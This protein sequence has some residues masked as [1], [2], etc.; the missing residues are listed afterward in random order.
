MRRV[1][2]EELKELLRRREAGEKI[3]LEDCFLEGMDLSG[4][5]LHGIAFDRSDICNVNLEGAN[6]SACTARNACFKGSSLK[7][8]NLKNAILHS[9]D[10]RGCDLSGAD[11]CGADM[12]SSALHKA[13]LSGIVTDE[14]TKFFYM[15]C[16][17][18]G[19]FIGWKVCFGRKVVMLLVPAD[20]KRVQ[21]TTREIRCDKA[22]VLT[23]KSVDL[24]EQFEEA[25]SYVDE[26]FIYKRGEMVYAKNFE[27]NRFVESAGGI[28]I[29]MSREE[30][31][32]YM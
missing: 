1:A 19:A 9:A 12:F 8:A 29:W 31:V 14:H 20:A 32:A 25:H 15:R 30:A 26:N 18:E 6:L 16:P 13:N 11:I 10:F 24:L 2:L 21:G 17:E 4:Y 27:P 3:M 23:I 5:D 28:H 7:N 22:K